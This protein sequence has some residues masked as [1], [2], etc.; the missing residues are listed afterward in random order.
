MCLLLVRTFDAFRAAKSTAP[1]GDS[2][3]NLGWI[4]KIGRKALIL[5][6]F[7]VF[8]GWRYYGQR[9]A[10]LRATGGVTTGEWRRQGMAFGLPISNFPLA[11]SLTVQPTAAISASAFLAICLR[12]FMVSP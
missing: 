1:S 9:V 6:A 7:H 11:Y 3:K 8:G 2:W 10:L 12:V 4:F 5:L